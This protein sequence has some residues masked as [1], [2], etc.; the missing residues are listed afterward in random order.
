MDGR[1]RDSRFEEGNTSDSDMSI[2]YQFLTKNLTYI[3]SHVTPTAT[4]V[5]NGVMAHF[6]LA[7]DML[8]D[9]RIDPGPLMTH[10]FP[11]SQFPEAYMNASNYENEV[12]KTI[13]TWNEDWEPGLVPGGGGVVASGAAGTSACVPCGSLVPCGSFQPSSKL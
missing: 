13:V 11:S 5:M 12:I 6:D 10:T 1:H 8:A 4:D 7:M 3:T 2:R 9:G